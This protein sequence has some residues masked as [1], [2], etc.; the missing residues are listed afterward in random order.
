MSPEAH[1]IYPEPQEHHSPHH[2]EEPVVQPTAMPE[3]PAPLQDQPFAEPIVMPISASSMAAQ[4][5]TG[6]SELANAP[7][8]AVVKTLSTRG[9]EYLFMS[10]ALWFA[11]TGLAWALLLLVNGQ[12]KAQLLAFPATSL[13]VCGPLFAWFFIRLK[14]AEIANP[15]LRFDA[16]KRRTSQITQTIAYLASLLNIITFVYLV[17]ASTSGSNS[18]SIGKSVLNLL[19]ILVVAGGILAYYWVDEHRSFSK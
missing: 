10:I 8:I 18:I 13:V 14:K 1:S 19:V 2:H 6:L 15:A 5:D 16:S 17:I 9:L 7:S 12:T 4:Q 3:P 11:A